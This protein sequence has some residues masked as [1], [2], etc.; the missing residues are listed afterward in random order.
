MDQALTRGAK[1]TELL[2]T[3]N[4]VT[5]GIKFGFTPSGRVM[6]DAETGARFSSFS[7]LR[8]L[9]F[10][11]DPSR[12]VPTFRS[13]LE[14]VLNDLATFQHW[15]LGRHGD[16]SRLPSPHRLGS[17]ERL[18]LLVK[19][20]LVALGDQQVFVCLLSGMSPELLRAF[21]SRICGE[22]RVSRETWPAVYKEAPF[23]F[24]RSPWYA[25]VL[26]IALALSAIALLE[27][28]SIVIGA[29]GSTSLESIVALESSLSVAGTWV[30]LRSK[31]KFSRAFGHVNPFELTEALLGWIL[32]PAVTLSSLGDGLLDKTDLSRW[33][34][35]AFLPGG[36][37][38]IVTG[39][40][41][42]MPPAIAVA[43]VFAA[44]LIGWVLALTGTK[45]ERSLRMPLA[46][47]F[48]DGS[49]FRLKVSTAV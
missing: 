32:A 10:I 27:G 41:G 33:I 26:C 49:S 30:W 42:Y 44:I 4:A 13:L 23:Q 6:A 22:G 20:L 37:W 48:R 7:S 29:R 35:F 12:P 11:G 31:S 21:F 14:I 45:R 8:Q 40:A 3:A 43:V 28:L 1:I 39:L 34:T 2:D 36:V 24:S 38:L 15:E 25:G 18:D 5:D 17:G 47:L 9:P 46:G 16:E 19:A